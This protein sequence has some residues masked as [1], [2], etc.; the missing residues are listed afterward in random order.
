MGNA[1]I[2]REN[3]RDCWIQGSHL[4]GLEQLKELVQGINYEVF[5]LFSGEDGWD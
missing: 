5:S 1:E 4:P 3:S 2:N